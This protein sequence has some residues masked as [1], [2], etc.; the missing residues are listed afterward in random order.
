M[1]K[2]HD[3]IFVVV[4]LADGQTV[5]LSFGD[6]KFPTTCEKV[7]PKEDVLGFTD[8]FEGLVSVSCLLEDDLTVLNVRSYLQ[9]V[10]D[11][12]VVLDAG[13]FFD[14][15]FGEVLIDEVCMNPCVCRFDL[16]LLMFGCGSFTHEAIITVFVFG[17]TV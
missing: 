8:D 2:G 7:L 10:V 11:T 17:S 5:D 15:S 13:G 3:R 9:I 16:L 14:T 1:R 12:V 4:E 6:D